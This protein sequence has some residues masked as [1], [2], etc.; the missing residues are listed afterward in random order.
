VTGPDQ[1]DPEA[2]SGPPSSAEPSAPVQQP[3]G[4]PDPSIVPYSTSSLPRSIAVGLSYELSA[5]DFTYDSPP[6]EFG[7]AKPKYPSAAVRVEA[8]R[9]LNTCT[10]VILDHGP[11]NSFDA[12]QR[13]LAE[14]PPTGMDGLDMLTA[15]AT[16]AIAAHLNGGI[17]PHLLRIDTVSAPPLPAE[18]SAPVLRRM[19]SAHG[20]ALG[21]LIYACAAQSGGGPRATFPGWSGDQRRDATHCLIAA[22]AATLRYWVHRHHQLSDPAE[23][24]SGSEP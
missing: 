4:E 19:W 3:A 21:M 9:R 2:S 22:Y 16:S 1:P 18:Q 10:E 11:T 14:P 15:I 20:D 6:P 13:H 24:A 23:A 7:Y 5:P 17:P 12:V 8:E